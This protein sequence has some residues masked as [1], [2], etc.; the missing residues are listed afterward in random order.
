MIFSTLPF[1]CVFLPVVFLAYLV[2]PS[3][4]IR[5]IL[6]IVASLFFYAYGEP[7]YVLLMIASVIINWLVGIAIGGGRLR[8]D[9]QYAQLPQTT[10]L[11]Q[12]VQAPHTLHTQNNA[13]PRQKL[14]LILAIIINLGFIAVFKYAGMVAQP[15]GLL[16]GGE[17]PFAHIALPIGISFYTFQALSYVI[18]VYRGVTPPQRNLLRLMLFISF[19]PQLIAGPIIRYHDIEPQL[20]KRQVTVGGVSSGLRR[21][22]VGLAK[23]V[24]IS[25]SLGELASIVYDAPP[26]DVNIAVAWIGAL[27]YLGHIYFDFS[28]YS[29]MAIGMARMFGFQ[30]RENFDYPYISRSVQEFWRRWHISLSSWFREYLYIPLGGSRNGR[31]RTVLNK[32]IV[33][34][35]CGL[36]HGANWTF[37]VWGLFHG[38]FLLLEEYLPIKKLPRALGWLYTLLV[39]CIGFVLF[40]SESFGQAMFMLGQMFTGFSFEPAQVARAAR[41][42]DPYIVF[43][44]LV[45]IVAATP[46]TKLLRQRL[47]GSRPGIQVSAQALSYGG[48]L[49]LIVICLLAL[50]SGGYNPFIYFRF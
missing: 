20:T 48:A 40:S 25:N 42:L 50:S 10:Q 49:G 5:N 39:V 4:K 8:Q 23:K 9:S 29:C 37:L 35:L 44:F 36:W 22:A 28:G 15:L 43:I 24:L 32:L 16:I 47:A 3:T 18:D 34:G 30:F 12:T 31:P 33:F 13:P 19:F 27:A 38:F 41:L 11:P 21:F 2:I 6:L 7:I 14:L 26:S 1:I 45:A 46:V 17:L